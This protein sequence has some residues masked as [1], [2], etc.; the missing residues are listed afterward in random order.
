MAQINSAKIR[1]VDDDELDKLLTEE[2]GPRAADLLLVPTDGS[3]P[4]KIPFSWADAKAYYTTYCRAGNDCDD[5]TFD[6]DCTHFMCHGLYSAKVTVNTP[7]TK[8]ASG[9]CIRVAELAA[10]FKNSVSKY[11]N[12][13]K[14]A[15]LPDSRE[16]D[17]CF[18]VSWFGLSKDHAMALAGTVGSTGGNVY[19]HT[20][21]RCGEYV[22]L[23]GETLVVYRIE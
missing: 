8:C 14:I 18:V 23:T 6:L 4:D 19:G 11:T 17:Y 2:L 15:K 13:R 22:D 12:V 16:G 9:L 7:A 3:S 21:N 10:A 1:L 20:N 5:G